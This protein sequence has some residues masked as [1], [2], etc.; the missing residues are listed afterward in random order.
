MEEI[1]DLVFF[2]IWAEKRLRLADDG[3]V[4]T[5]FSLGGE[6]EES[7]DETEQTFY[8]NTTFSMTI[9]TDWAIHVPKP[10]T[11]RHITYMS[12]DTQDQ[13]ALLNDEQAAR[14]QTE[15]QMDQN[16]GLTLNNR[17]YVRDRTWN[18]ETIA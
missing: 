2:H 13:M 10:L 5:D 11:F 15:V 8:Y 14:L 16:L 9:Q 18:Y 7:Y 12:Q 3:L 17:M 1:A 4:L 6:V